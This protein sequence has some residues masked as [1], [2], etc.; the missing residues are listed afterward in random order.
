MKT[1]CTFLLALAALCSLQA[2][3]RTVN[4]PPFIVRNS[5]TVEID[6]I[7][8][9]DTATV[10]DIKAF[11]R[12]HNW[13]RISSES[14]LLGDDGVKYPI[15]SGNGIALDTEFWMPE[16]GEASFSLIFSA[17]PP[18]VKMVDFIESDCED[19][20]KVWGIPLDGKLPKLA[21]PKEAK[22][23]HEAVPELPA[24][25]LKQGKAVLS[26]KL[27]D[28]RKHYRT[29]LIV[30]Y[31]DLLTGNEDRQTIAVADDGSFR[32]EVELHAPT[33]VWLA[34]GE[35]RKVHTLFLVPGEETKVFV[36][37]REL[38]RAQSKLLKDT[39]PSGQ[40]MYFAGAMAGLNTALSGKWA[41]NRYGDDAFLKDYMA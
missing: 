30:S 18:S 35:D 19:C 39:K 20:F 1:L 12:P 2:K 27:L 31:C 38:S 9:S 14:Y 23:K 36:N 6:R 16:S 40:P 37:L 15:R 17:L 32:T 34:V 7:V 4:R 26:G 11:F 33:C 10:V 28:Y 22:Q 8:A 5:S 41:E 24:V 25:T 29:N 3:D 13:I 21:L